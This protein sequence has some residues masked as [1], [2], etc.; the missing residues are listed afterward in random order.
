MLGLVG[1]TFTA[2]SSD[3]QTDNRFPE[4]KG[5]VTIK[6]ASPTLSR[7]VGN[8]N[9]SNVTVAPAAGSDVVITLTD[10]TSQG[11]A[12]QTITLSAAE[13]TASQQVTFWNV[14]APQSISVTMNGGTASYA[15]VSVVA[16]GMQ[17]VANVPAYGRT[18]DFTLTA[19]TIS[20]ETADDDHE[21]GATTD[22]IGK[23]YQKYE[24]T[25]ALAIPVARLEVSGI[26]H[27]SAAHA[28]DD[29]AY[30]TLT[31][32]GVYMDNVY[33]QGTDVTYSAGADG[34]SF[35]CASGTPADYCWEYSADNR[36]GTGATALLKDELGD[37][38]EKNFLAENAVWP[39]AG[40]AY[41]Y[42]FF[43]ADGEQNLPIFKIYFDTSAAQAGGTPLP[44]PRYAMISKYKNT[45]GDV[46]KFEPGRI[47][48]I[49][50]AALSDTNIIGDE[51]GN[52]LYGVEVTVEEAQWVVEEIS[53]DWAQ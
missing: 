31:I 4:G 43:G 16:I 3:E 25:V 52:T 26:T 37:T 29:C 39:S 12:T 42:N 49:T 2:C 36:Y 23:K 50:S 21:S 1:L 41:G 5:A 17:E 32:A 44:A 40:Q 22:D 30:Q 20:P 18:E 35:S 14:T 45:Q 8:G 53:A 24:A 47:Y 11:D 34:A 27:I 13:W 9:S 7:A 51:S 10:R 38:D 33:A 15:G 48:R 28:A 19:Q 46:V 6:I